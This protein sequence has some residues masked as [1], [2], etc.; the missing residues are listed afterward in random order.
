MGDKTNIKR[1]QILISDNLEILVKREISYPQYRRYLKFVPSNEINAL[2]L[3]S[4]G[5][6]S[7]WFPLTTTNHEALTINDYLDQVLR[8]TAPYVKDIEEFTKIWNYS[9]LHCK[10][11]FVDID[12]ETGDVII[13]FD[14]L[15]YER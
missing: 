9:L 14:N 8:P 15:F 13:D 4:K 2:V 10:P 12:Y 6:Q 3:S 5:G 11:A 1:L 7:G